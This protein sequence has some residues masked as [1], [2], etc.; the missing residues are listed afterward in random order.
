MRRSSTKESNGEFLSQAAGTRS[1]VDRFVEA[2]G[3]AE[4]PGWLPAARQYFAHLDV[5]EIEVGLSTVEA[6]ATPEMR[7]AWEHYVELAV[8][9]HVVP[10]VALELRLASELARERPDRIEPIVEHLR[11]H[12]ADIGLLEWARVPPPLLT[13]IARGGLRQDPGGDGESSGHA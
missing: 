7:G 5:G 3:G 8:G 2:L 4:P 13:Y 12:G 6:P 9:R 10:A 11:A 1:D